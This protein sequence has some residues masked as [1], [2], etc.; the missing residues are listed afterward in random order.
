M[1]IQ[2]TWKINQMD[3]YIDTQIVYNVHFA[4]ETS[5]SDYPDYLMTQNMATGIPHN[6][7]VPVVPYDQLTEEQVIDW[8]KSE[9]KDWQRNLE[10]GE[11][12]L[13]ENGNRISNGDLIPGILESGERQLNEL[14]HPVVETVQLPWL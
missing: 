10:T 9:L 3:R 13:D 12:I 4:I 8:V 2:H 6:E 7:N 14:I 1:A 11:F 5:D